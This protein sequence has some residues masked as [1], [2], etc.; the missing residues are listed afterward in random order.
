[1]WSV[2]LGQAPRRVQ[3]LLTQASVH[4]GSQP[5]R[6]QHNALLHKILQ[7]WKCSVML[8]R[9]V[10]TTTKQCAGST[11]QQLSSVLIMIPSIK[12]YCVY[13]TFMRHG[14]AP[15]VSAAL[16]QQYP[17]YCRPLKHIHTLEPPCADLNLLGEV[18]SLKVESLTHG[19][20]WWA[21]S[22]KG[23]EM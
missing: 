17:G 20:F 8:C 4:W 13:L 14:K 16:F 12:L 15:W 9:E 1:M 19:S 18:K 21:G 3:T 10:K 6:C 5:S 22:K 2:W 11:A 23:I 7:L